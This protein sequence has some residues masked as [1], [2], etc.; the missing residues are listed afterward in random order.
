[1]E[2][3]GFGGVQQGGTVASNL[4]LHA[5]LPTSAICCRVGVRRGGRGEGG[6]GGQR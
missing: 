5:L 4:S 2:K 1:M 3:F 6:E